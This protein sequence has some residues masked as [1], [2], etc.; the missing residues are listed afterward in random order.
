MF[1][2]RKVEFNTYKCKGKDINGFTSKM[3]IK[4]PASWSNEMISIAVASMF[5]NVT[6]IYN[7]RNSINIEEIPYVSFSIYQR[8]FYNTFRCYLIGSEVIAKRGNSPILVE[9]KLT[10]GITEF[11]NYRFQKYKKQILI[12]NDESEDE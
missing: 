1:K 8:D 9:A 10:S 7:I 5:K 3:I 2:K 12:T 6:E 11:S 4:I